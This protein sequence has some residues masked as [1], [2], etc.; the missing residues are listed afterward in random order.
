MPRIHPLNHQLGVVRF[1]I[2]AID[3]MM[4]VAGLTF[5]LLVKQKA[6]YHSQDW[7]DSGLD[8]VKDFVLWVDTP[9][10]SMEELPKKY[11]K[12]DQNDQLVGSVWTDER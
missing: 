8:D 5:E 6:K 4:K 1:R 3:E 11:S 10:S 12:Y 2:S 9:Y 7:C